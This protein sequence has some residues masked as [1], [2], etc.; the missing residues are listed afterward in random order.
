MLSSIGPLFLQIGRCT[1]FPRGNILMASVQLMAEPLRTCG[2]L[3]GT[4]KEAWGNDRSSA[5]GLSRKWRWWGEE[6]EKEEG[7][8]SS[9]NLSAAA[10]RSSAAAL[11]L[12]GPLREGCRVRRGGRDRRPSIHPPRR[13][14]SALV[15][16]LSIHHCRSS[17]CICVSGMRN[18]RDQL[19]GVYQ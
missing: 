16:A 5:R 3:Y 7:C 14:S 10:S 4:E 11:S 12:S 8:S 18:D 9:P 6:G 13:I 15:S 19:F 1:E 2:I 17:A